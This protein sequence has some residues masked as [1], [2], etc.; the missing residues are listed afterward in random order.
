MSKIIGLG[1]DITH[2]PRIRLAWERFGARFENRFLHIA[3]KERLRG[4]D[5]FNR[6]QVEFLASRWAA[7]EAAFKA[8]KSSTPRVA[9]TDLCILNRE[10]GVPF[11]ELCGSA[12]VVAKEM[13]VKETFLSLSHDTDYAI[14][15]VILQTY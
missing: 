2:I 3:E 14:A 15:Q 6:K 12:E 13:G 11:L 4:Y 10:N 8:L 5:G 9:F 7:K 1:V